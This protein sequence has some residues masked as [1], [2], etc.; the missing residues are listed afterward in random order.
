MLHYL[1]KKQRADNEGY[2]YF[3]NFGGIHINNWIHKRVII[4]HP[5]GNVTL[6]EIQEDVTAFKDKREHYNDF[7]FTAENF[8]SSDYINNLQLFFNL[9]STDTNFAKVAHKELNKLNK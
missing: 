2:V 5:S 6:S 7:G 4:D 3:P 9:L 1:I 8:S